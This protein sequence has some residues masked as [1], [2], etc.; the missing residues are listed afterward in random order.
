M[1]VTVDGQTGTF[2]GLVCDSQRDDILVA[3]RMH[4][5]GLMLRLY[6]PSK[7]YQLRS[8]EESNDGEA[9]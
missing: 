6:H 5:H 4:G 2:V 9:E 8:E 1:K 7:V 3:V